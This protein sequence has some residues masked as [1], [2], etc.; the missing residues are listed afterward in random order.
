M[1]LSFE[2]AREFLP[3]YLTPSDQ[4][5]LFAELQKLPSNASWYAQ[6]N[7]AGI[8]QGDCLKDAPYVNLSSLQEKK[9]RAFVLSNTCD[10]SSDN[11]RDI[12]AQVTF[13]P[14]LPISAFSELL[15]QC[16]IPEKVIASKIAS[17]ERQL[18]TSI[19][20]LP[21]NLPELSEPHVALLDRVQSRPASDL[22]VPK[23]AERVS[24]LS[25]CGFWFLL[26]KLAIHYCR[27]QEGRARGYQP[28]AT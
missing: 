6:I 3:K 16:G 26:M 20:Y 25:Q 28:V 18:V 2:D 5:E 9:I 21:A 14:L 24:R 11:P 10:I 12:P 23:G 1:A 8:W 17:C 13:C 7:D 27:A 4:R 22:I 19:F 15:K